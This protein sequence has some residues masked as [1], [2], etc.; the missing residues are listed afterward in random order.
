MLF[1]VLALLV[2]VFWFAVIKRF[3]KIEWRPAFVT[4][5]VLCITIMVFG[6]FTTPFGYSEYELISE[7]EI[8]PNNITK[9]SVN[10][11]E[12]FIEKV[13]DDVY[14]FY[15]VSDYKKDKD[16]YPSLNIFYFKSYLDLCVLVLVCTYKFFIGTF[17]YLLNLCDYK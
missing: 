16:Y 3:P 9:I 2:I 5:A 17:L 13:T 6:F 11:G 1:I 12:I 14:T 15:C 7:T 10:N 8:N 4:I